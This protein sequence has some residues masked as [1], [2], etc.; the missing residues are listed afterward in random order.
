[1]QK[2][3]KPFF[4]KIGI[5]INSETSWTEVLEKL[6]ILLKIALKILKKLFKYT[7]VLQINSKPHLRCF[8]K[9][10]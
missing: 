6:K 4:E 5:M 3:L 7:D 1:M 10:D 9:G 8:R 2:V